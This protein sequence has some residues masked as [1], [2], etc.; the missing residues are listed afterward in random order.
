MKKIWKKIC[1][2]TIIDTLYKLKE[3]K[4]Y[5]FIKGGIFKQGIKEFIINGN[6]FFGKIEKTIKFDCILNYFK[7]KENYDFSEEELEKKLKTLI[8]IKKLKNKYNNF[9][10]K[11]NFSIIQK[12][13]GKDWDMAFVNKSE[14]DK[15]IIINLYLIQISIN[16]KIKEI[17]NI[18]NNISR[19]INYIKK[20]IFEIL[21]IV[22]KKV[23]IFFIFNKSTLN[24]KKIPFFNKYKIPFIFYEHK[25]RNFVS[26][27]NIVIDFEKLKKESSFDEHVKD[28][29]LS[30]LGEVIEEANIFNE[31]GI[32]SSDNEDEE[33]SDS[34][35]VE[36]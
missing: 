10:F 23:Y 13:N 6:Y 32:I 34:S 5:N 21:G 22:I 9:I 19:K 24:P 29:E 18:F 31:E 11:N 20:K 15:K 35:Y 30:L 4:L 28:W 27:E 7:T 33:S 25:I 3:Y 1:K 17:Q 8:S 2:E 16:I 26:K 36:T 14:I 12:N